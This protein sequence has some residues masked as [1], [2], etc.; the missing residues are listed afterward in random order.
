MM[1]LCGIFSYISPD[2]YMYS[3]IFAV[4]V[5]TNCDISTMK[6]VF[7]GWCLFSDQKSDIVD[8]KS[9]V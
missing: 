4:Q 7:P 2:C 9:V 8:R 1:R 6:P 3:D 5:Q